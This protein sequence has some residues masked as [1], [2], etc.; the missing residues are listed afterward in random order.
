MSPV[1][2]TVI[3]SPVGPLRLVATDAALT[4]VYF[5]QH[6]RAPAPTSSPDA[7]AATQ[8]PVLARAAAEL[9]EYFAGARSAFSVDLAPE[10][11]DFQKAVWSALREIP[12]G[13]KV[14]YAELGRRLGRPSASRAVGSANARNPLSIIVPCHRVVGATGALTGYAGGVD[15]KAW[16]LAHESARR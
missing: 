8:H 14:S 6:R 3:P 16:L 4:G 15:A 7:A 12:F 9:A 10:G 13:A 5:A 1:T 2:E 11:T